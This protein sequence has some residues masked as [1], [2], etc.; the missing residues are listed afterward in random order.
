MLI[1]SFF[2]WWYSSGWSALLDKFKAII[3]SITTI[4]SVKTI[5]KTLFSPWKRIVRGYSGNIAIDIRIL[6]DNL[7][8]RWMGFNIRILFLTMYALLTFTLLIILT[9]ML[10]IWPILPLMP[11]IAPIL[12]WLYV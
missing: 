6:F 2:S 4:L 10:I 5:I 1:I 11:I 8:S 7:F 3:S 12:V 9:I